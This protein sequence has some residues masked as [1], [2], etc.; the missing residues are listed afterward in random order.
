MVTGGCY[1]RSL[2]KPF[3][4]TLI[5]CLS[6]LWVT[7]LSKTE[8]TYSPSVNSS[9]Q[10][11]GS[12]PSSSPQQSPAQQPNS[13]LGIKHAP[14]RFVLPRR[15]YQCA[16]AQVVAIVETDAIRLTLNGNGQVYELKKT[17]STGPTTKY[18]SGSI[19]WSSDVQTGTLEDDSDP[20]HPK[21]LAKACYLQS[22]FPPGS[23]ANSISGTLNFAMPKYLPPG[24]EIWIQ[25]LDLK[26]VDQLHKAIGIRMFNILGR[27][28]PIPF[29]LKFDPQNIRSKDCCA[30]YAEIRVDDKP[31]YATSGPQPIPDITHPAPV[32]LELLPIHENATRP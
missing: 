10:P 6:L 13:P 2:Q 8:P 28:P 22:A 14:I 29:E 19:V 20:V 25:L 9:Q 16:G 27:K 5:L 30:L 18:A 12:T 26:P 1:H 4:P 21:V 7:R 31:A 3:W 15:V 23:P 17:E 24:A 11:T 32:K